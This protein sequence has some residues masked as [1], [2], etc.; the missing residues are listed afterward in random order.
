MFNYDRQHEK[1]SDRLKNS[2]PWVGKHGG[3]V[4]KNIYTKKLE[5]KNKNVPENI[6]KIIEKMLKVNP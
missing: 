4:L 3:E 6:V 5:M 1:A 2:L